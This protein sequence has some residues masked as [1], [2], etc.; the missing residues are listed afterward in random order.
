MIKV[1]NLLLKGKSGDFP[2][3]PVERF[4]IK[5]DGIENS[6]PTS[7]LRH[8]L[9]LPKAILDKYNLLAGDLRENI[10]I[11]GFDIHELPSGTILQIGSVKI[12]LTY[13]CEPCKRIADIVDIKKIVHQRG[14]LGSFLNPGEIVIGDE[15]DILQKKLEA[16]PYEVKAR[17]RW[18]ID[19]LKQ[20]ISIKQL[21]HEL[22]L[23]KSY[24]RAIPN[25]LKKMGSKYIDLVDYPSKRKHSLLE[26]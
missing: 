16:I 19:K 5:R 13:H 9:V 21:A 23:S 26:K 15:V 7:P 14:Y 6:V 24:Y 11:D 12:R 8:V 25:M 10:V 17:V 2:M 3:T 20:P 18:Y 22:G 1:T 4:M